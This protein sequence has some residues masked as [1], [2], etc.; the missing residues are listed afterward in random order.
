[1]RL[2]DSKRRIAASG[3]RVLD[4]GRR[5]PR[6]ASCFLDRGRGCVAFGAG[7]GHVIRR[8]GLPFEE[9]LDPAQIVVRV[10]SLGLHP[11]HRRFGRRSLLLGARELSGR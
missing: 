6:A 1:M 11:G 2:L 9:R 5:G 8:H 10:V 7:V 3:H 4:R